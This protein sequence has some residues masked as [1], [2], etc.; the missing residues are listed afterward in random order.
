MKEGLVRCELR[1]DSDL[2]ENLIEACKAINISKNQL[3]NGLLRGAMDNL[4]LVVNKAEQ[5]FDM[6]P[7]VIRKLKELSNAKEN[8]G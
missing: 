6:K 5:K 8:E 7:S 2:N 1:I 4:A 3:V